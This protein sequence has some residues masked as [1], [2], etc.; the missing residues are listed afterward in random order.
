MAGFIETLYRRKVRPAVTDIRVG[1][2]LENYHE[3]GASDLGELFAP[4]EGECP[5]R[6]VV[7]GRYEVDDLGGVLSDLL[8]EVFGNHAIFVHRHAHAPGLE[9]LEFL[10]AVYEGGGFHQDDITRVD[11]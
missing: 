11:K 4:F 7:E 5:P 1:F 9:H 8:L 2:V 10:H 6:R 3:T